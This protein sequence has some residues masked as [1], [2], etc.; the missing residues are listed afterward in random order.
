MSARNKFED[1]SSNTH[2]NR[3]KHPTQQRYVSLSPAWDKATAIGATFAVNVNI[4]LDK[5]LLCAVCFNTV[6]RTPVSNSFGMLSNAK[7]YHS[8]CSW[9]IY[10]S[11]VEK[12]FC[13]G[14]SCS[15]LQHLPA[16]SIHNSEG[17]KAE[18]F[19][20]KEARIKE[21]STVYCNKLECPYIVDMV[22]HVLKASIFEYKS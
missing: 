19:D 16:D 4:I 14:F 13:P 5:L 3:Y 18:A 2:A 1:K 7:I 20:S 8:V 15:T 6:L 10:R 12:T 22:E 9:E 17:M 21:L 11:M